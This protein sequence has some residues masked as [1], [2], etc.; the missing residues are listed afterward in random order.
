MKSS[1]NK[2]T[3]LFDLNRI[4]TGGFRLLSLS[5]Q[6]RIHQEEEAN[7]ENTISDRIEKR[8][9]ETQ[10]IESFN[11]APITARINP[12]DINPPLACPFLKTDPPRNAEIKLSSPVQ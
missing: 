3:N 7:T 2:E 5:M 4:E 6:C 12:D 9:K 10:I 1:P 8:E 11:G